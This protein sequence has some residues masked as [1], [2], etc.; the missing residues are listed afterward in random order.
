MWFVDLDAV[1]DHG[2]FGRF[3][4]ADHLGDPDRS[5]RDNINDIV[6]ARGLPR[7]TR[8]L[9]A[10]QPRAM[11]SGFNSISVFWCLDGSDDCTAVVV[12]VHN[13]YGGQHAYVVEP[14][15]AGNARTDKELYV[16]PFHGTDGSYRVHVPVPTA[17]VP[18]PDRLDF[19]IQLQPTSSGDA[20]FSASLEGVR[21]D[22]ASAR[23]IRRAAWAALRGSALIHAHGIVLWARRLP[24]RPRPS[25]DG[26][27]S[28]S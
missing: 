2:R 18:G 26:R 10:T 7:P 22:D 21:I 17:P 6:T 27:V 19:G 9:M 24:V 5:I 13:T 11:G 28:R 3:L 8:I 15:A 12:E 1:P 4:G 14:D 16:S 20:P 23:D 25:A